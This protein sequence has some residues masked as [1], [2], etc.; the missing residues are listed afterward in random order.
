MAVYFPYNFGGESGRSG[1]DSIQVN[2]LPTA[3]AE[4]LGKVYQYIG[5]TTPNRINGYFY[6]CVEGSTSGTYEWSN[7]DVQNN[8]SGGTNIYYDVIPAHTYL[9]GFDINRPLTLP[10]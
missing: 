3:S 5:E 4:N 8:G 1:G 7:I 2:A 9:Y 10:K 6:K